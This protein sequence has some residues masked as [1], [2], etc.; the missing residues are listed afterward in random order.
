MGKPLEQV[1][2]A[3]LSENPEFDVCAQS[4]PTLYDLLD[5]ISS[6]SSVHGILR[7]RILD[8]VA[9]PSCRRSSQHRDLTLV[10]CISC[11]KILYHWAIK[12]VHTWC[13]MLC[14]CSLKTLSNVIIE[15]IFCK[16]ILLECWSTGWEFEDQTLMVFMAGGLYP[17]GPQSWPISAPLHF[18]C[19]LVSVVGIAVAISAP[20]WQC[21][22]VFGRWLNWSSW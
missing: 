7:A 14:S 22:A 12:E 5:Y 9:M 20:C 1:N 3:P 13:L 8:W 11:I 6:G 19:V 15:L 10:S 17:T 16:W 4:C 21:Q 18:L 2:R